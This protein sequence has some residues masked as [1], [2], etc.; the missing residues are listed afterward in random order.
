[1]S[2]SLIKAN[3]NL[4]AVLRN[5]ED[6]VRHDPAA[7]AAAADW[8]VAIQF[9]VRRG[10][11]AWVAF[12]DGGCTFGRGRHRSPDVVLWFYN[13]SHL[14]RMMDGK[15]TPIPLKG[16][17]RL[18]FMSR[19]FAKVTARLEYFLK[20]DA[21]RLA[22]PA[23]LALNTRLTIAT[24]VHAARE[25]ALFDPVGR[26]AA[27]HIRDGTVQLKVLPDGPAAHIVFAGGEVTPGCGEVQRPMARMD[28]R[29]MA[30]ANAFLN[31]KIDP[32]TAI[33]VGDV[34]IRGQ[35]SMLD[36]LSLIFDRIPGYL[37]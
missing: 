33:A 12:K 37:G 9:T 29:D 27:A 16:F 2:Q 15:A 21:A 24:A 7:A 10:P 1:M 8:H 25:L 23:Y 22:D 5:L 20:P 13:A 3:L 11:A 17:T 19:E 30:T 32:F 35:T 14:N 31:G 34:A 36:S 18:G 26:L 28:M 6:L 4:Y